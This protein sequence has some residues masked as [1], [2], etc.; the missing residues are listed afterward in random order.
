MLESSTL[1]PD[2][3][4]RKVREREVLRVAATL[5]AE[6]ARAA[7]EA[8][9]EILKW[10]QNRIGALL[11]GAAW[12]LQGFQH[13]GAGRE[14]AAVRIENDGDDIWAI[15]TNDP[16]K[17][18]AQRTWT[19]EI[20]IGCYG[21]VYFSLRLLMS[22][23]E[24][25]PR[26][27]PAVPGLL[28]Q[29]N[30]SIGLTHGTKPVEDK[31]IVVESK[32]G[33]DLLIGD[34]I[35]PTR[36]IPH[37][38]LTVPADAN[39]PLLDAD[40]LARRTVGIAKVIVVRASFTWPLTNYFGKRLSVFEGAIRV[41][42]PGFTEDANPYDHK[43]FFVGQAGR[44]SVTGD[45]QR[46]IA[47][48]SLRQFRLDHEVLAYRTVRDRYHELNRKKLEVAATDR[49]Q[50]SAALEQVDS[51]KEN[52]KSKEEE[53]EWFARQHDDAESRARDFED[54]WRKASF[55]IRT[56]TKQLRSSGG[57]PD[58]NIDLPEDWHRFSDWCDE[59]FEH[60]V[61]ILNAARKEMKNATFEDV[62]LAARCVIWLANEY[63]EKRQH[64][65]GDDLRTNVSDGIHNDRCGGD[66][67]LASWQ[68]KRFEVDWHIKNGGN[69]RDPRRCLRIYYFWHDESQR[70]VIAS[71]PAHRRT[72]AT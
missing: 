59:H 40:F 9:R 30:T 27:E 53:I 55:R 68:G 15:R 72:G 49:V 18:V 58:S 16:D 21:Q 71:M 63:R 45:L 8:K 1:Q 26:V 10:T 14:C 39:E 52:L 2:Q 25:E 33:T 4:S 35:D 24:D 19:T 43:L 46:M 61:V 7:D 70:V 6:D 5:Q 64:G 51:L 60:R 41:Y 11:P 36:K 47:K 54:R 22:S 13:P 44:D 28:Q 69:T 66:M 42:L 23:H 3:T 31:P 65:Y 12:D 67:F 34:L 20:V 37:V 56:L 32:E 17:N 38:V 57:E 62:V 50:L 29:L 48:L